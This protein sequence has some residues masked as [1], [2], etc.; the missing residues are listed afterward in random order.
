MQFINWTARNM[1]KAG[2]SA[3]AGARGPRRAMKGGDVTSDEPKG[4]GLRSGKREAF[5]CGNGSAAILW[6]VRG[7]GA[8]GIATLGELSRFGFVLNEVGEG[9]LKVVAQFNFELLAALP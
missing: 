9:C 3:Q 4:E 2:A 6:R 7:G 8:S 1:P 5:G